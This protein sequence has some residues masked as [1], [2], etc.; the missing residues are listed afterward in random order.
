M[1][2]STGPAVSTHIRGSKVPDGIPQMFL[3]KLECYLL[4]RSCCTDGDPF[5]MRL[6]CLAVCE[7]CGL[8]KADGDETIMFP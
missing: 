6:A 5:L 1:K 3:R 7:V 2:P 8:P 4:N